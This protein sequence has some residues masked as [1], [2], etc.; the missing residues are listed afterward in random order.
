MPGTLPLDD[1][2]KEVQ[3]HGGGLLKV[4]DTWY[5]FGESYKRP[6]LGDFLSE[7]VNLYSSTD[8][9]TW[10]YEGLVFN[11]TAQ[12]T[13][14]PVDPPYR[15]ERPK[16]LYN[17]AYGDFV[18]LFH[19]DTPKFTFPTVG[20]ARAKD[21]TGPYEWVHVIHPD[22]LNSFDMGVWQEDDGSAYLVRSVNNEYVGI[23]PLSPDYTTTTGLVST[24]P[25]CEGPSIFKPS[26]DSY[27][28]MASHLTGWAPNPPLLYHAAAT[29]VNGAVWRNTTTPA[30]GDGA[31]ITYNSQSTFVFSL[32][33][34][35]GTV[36]YIYMGDRW[37][38]YGPG[39][40]EKASYV[41]LPLLPR[42]DGRGYELVYAEKW[43]PSDYHERARIPVL[44][45]NGSTAEGVSVGPAMPSA[46][47]LGSQ[48]SSVTEPAGAA[49]EV[50]PSKPPAG[51]QA[52]ASRHNTTVQARVMTPTLAGNASSSSNAS[53]A[54]AVP[55][56]S[57][58]SAA[59][60]AA[61]I[62][63]T[64]TMARKI[65]DTLSVALSG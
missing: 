56:N 55:R 35:D 12:M 6:L 21:I 42:L 16:I 53:T 10:H 15:I 57:V 63:S 47:G 52:F 43:S 1:A 50:T 13:G 48:S 17:A 59:A 45:N 61:Q 25:R 18:M 3:A 62:S 32:T 19:A 46:Q 29:S 30:S 58:A 38:F 39:K 31:N 54:P 34:E 33:F 20:V 9:A 37:N 49:A 65:A 2:G 26:A 14:M 40:V 27:F 51:W 64:E 11:G 5:W 28:L 41:W 60:S 7:G 8:L 24:A 23:S 22:G 44:Y 4:K 36:M